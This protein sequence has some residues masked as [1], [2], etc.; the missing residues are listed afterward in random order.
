MSLPDGDLV[1]GDPDGRF[2]L[3]LIGDWMPVE[4]DGA[5]ARFILADPAL[6]LYVVTTEADELEAGAEAALKVIGIDTSTSSLLGTMPTPHYDLYV[7]SF[8]GEQAVMV[9]VRRL[10]EGTLAFIATGEFGVLYSLPEHLWL[11]VDGYSAMPLAEYLEFR[12]PAVPR[13]AADIENLNTIA[14]YSGRTKL[15]G[16][17][18]LPE[19]EGSFPAIVYTGSGSGPTYRGEFSHHS[20]VTAGIAVFSY[21]KRGAGDSDG[22]L[23]PAG[24]NFGEWRLG[25]LADDAL[26]AVNFLQGLEEINPDQIGLMGTSQAGWTIP[27]AASRSDAVAYSVIVSGP[28][29]SLGEE[30]YW[31]EIAGDFNMISECK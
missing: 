3:P 22:I 19:G 28:T 9:A 5:Y 16:R 27:L 25:Q 15:V 4:T 21:D 30:A 23:I 20:Y 1:Y 26:A 10:G 6:E 13:T 2:S 24:F 7:Y 14:F 31:S 29:V 8:E 18:T 11:S 12:P 17:L